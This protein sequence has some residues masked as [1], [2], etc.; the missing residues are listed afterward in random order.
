MCTAISFNS[1]DHYFGR[2]LDLE[3][4]YNEAVTVTPRNFPFT[5][6]NGIEITNHPAIIGIAAVLE[7]YPLYYEASNE[8]GLSIAGLNFPG[9][10]YFPEEDKDKQNI[11][12]FEL[13]AWILCQC[14]TTYEAKK[15]MQKTNVANIDFTAELKAAPLHWIIAD[16]E[17]SIV[18]ECVKDGL[19]IYD[20]PV[21]ILTNNPPF[22]FQLQN[23]SKYMNLTAKEPENRFSKNLELQAVSKGMGAIGLPGDLSSISRFVRASF[24]KE[25]SV[26]G[27][28]EEESVG[29][30]FHVLSSVE[31][32]R[33][34]V[35][36]GKGM[37]EITIYTSCCN[38]DKGIYYYTTYSNRQITAVDMHRE[39]LDGAELIYYP[40]EF[41]EQ[42]NFIN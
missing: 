22:D 30:F 2:T 18:I 5:F 12:P 11:A 38:T 31:H 42:I 10:A 17:I 40:L 16:K 25:N 33:G 1:K 27:D 37:Y 35:D 34:A 3:Y 26:C 36:L 23:L 24:I 14:S 29:Q 21:G 20:N 41:D 39:N 15:L 6:R 9:N 19:K 4:H 28:S 32:Q 13:I 8:K 7:N